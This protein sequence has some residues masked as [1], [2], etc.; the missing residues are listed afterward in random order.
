MTAQ[1]LPAQATRPAHH[2]AHP[3][4]WRVWALLVAGLVL[5]ALVGRAL[6]PSEADVRSGTEAVT[7]QEFAAHTGVNVTL[8]GVTGGGGMIEFRYQ[9][10]D[11]DKASR[12]VHDD[13]LRPVLVV[14]DTG[15]TLVMSS[16]PHGHQAELKL[17]GS[18][19]FLLANA[20]NAIREGS[21]VTIVVGDVRLEHVAARA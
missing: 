18:Y 5:A 20:N 1:T 8:L 10:L 17:G 16:R 6:L 12:L 3:A 11:P 2:R 9:V 4:R 7:A 13:A 15:A 14:E 21:K 19:F